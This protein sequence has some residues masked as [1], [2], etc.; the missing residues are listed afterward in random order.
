MLAEGKMKYQKTFFGCSPKQ[1]YLIFLLNFK[2]R[3]E[4]IINS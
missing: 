4:I 2:I 3:N 1:D